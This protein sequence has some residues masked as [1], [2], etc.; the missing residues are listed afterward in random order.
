MGIAESDASW[1]G[2][3]A[4]TSLRLPLASLAMRLALR[5]GMREVC[6]QKVSAG[7]AGPA[8]VTLMKRKLSDR[9]NETVHLP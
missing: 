3:A 4:E 2:A 7:G 8:S 9:V 5:A 1:A 6:S